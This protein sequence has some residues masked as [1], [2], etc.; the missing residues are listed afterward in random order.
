MQRITLTIILLGV[1]NNVLYGQF[2]FERKFDVEVKKNN[3]VLTR[4]WEGGLNYPIF[5]NVD[6]DNNGINDLL[7]FDK[8]GSRL[9]V[10]KNHNL[11]FEN[12]KLDLKLERW[13]LFRDFNCDNFPDIFTGTSGG[14][15]VYKNNGDFTFTLE[16]IL[17]Q[18][19]L[20]TFTSNLFVANEDIPGITD[21]DGD[22]D[23]D[24]LTFDKN[25]VYLEYHKN[26]SI[27]KSEE[28]GLDFFKES[29]CWGSFKENE[30]TNQIIL[31]QP[32]TNIGLSILGGGNHAGSSI[33]T[34]DAD[35]NGTI[36]LIIGDISFN[37]LN[38]LQN[39][40]SSLFSNINL[41]DQ[42]FPN[43]DKK[44][45][46]HLFPYASY[47]DVNH[48]NRNDLLVV[49]NNAV[50]GDN[51]KVLFYKNIG[52]NKDT[53]SFQSNSFLIDKML[54]FGTS[55]YPIWVDE[56][57]DGLTDLLIGNNAINKNG[58]ISASLTLLRNTGTSLAPSYEIINEDYLGFS[59]NEEQYVYPAVGDI[60]RDGDEDLLIGLQSGKILLYINQAG[61]NQPYDFVF[62]AAEFEGID[63]GN[64]AA[65]V[66]FDV[67]GDDKIDLTVGEQNGSLYYYE[68]QTDNGYDYSIEVKNFGNISTQDF[69][70]GFFSGYSTPFFFLKDGKTHLLVGGESG[71]VKAYLDI[72]NEITT[73]IELDEDDFCSLKDGGYSKPL[74]GDLNGDKNPE[75]I[76]GNRSGGLAFYLGLNTENIN[77]S[78]TLK[79][80]DYIVYGNNIQF[81]SNQVL[82]IKLFDLNGKLIKFSRTNKVGLPS[83]S[84]AYIILLE[85]SNEIRSVK[86][87]K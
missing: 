80:I 69:N 70:A 14:I 59:S 29:D 35:H 66:L 50:I 76:V 61:A 26:Q 83:N 18:T 68:N 73:A 8:S 81:N 53:F 37:N 45:D 2:S 12:I 74:I 7:A 58:E 43:Y 15:R 38:F 47:I 19:D 44:I 64:Y 30:I 86:F 79:N 13:V 34:L 32:C 54:D 21:I 48:D 16:S 63:I 25:G 9:V 78:K 6:F 56:N 65:P 84:G 10:F 5:S 57:K 41:I 87:F 82:N 33:T 23:L 46:I 3:T 67:N 55:A 36:D 39:G 52:V 71:K 60:D 31:N 22:G 27:E 40:G 11:D 85:F 77:N 4:A 42:N 1:V 17:I 75:L 72:Q 24:I 28:C 51:K 20:G 49:S 62:A